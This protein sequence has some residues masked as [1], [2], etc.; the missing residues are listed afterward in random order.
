MKGSKPGILVLALAA[1]L[2]I[3]CRENKMSRRYFA[4]YVED[5][6]NGL[7]KVTEANGWAYHIQ[8]KPASYILANEANASGNTVEE[9][10][11]L[12]NRLRGAVWFNVSIQRIKEQISPLRYNATDESEYSARL[13]YFLNSAANDFYLIYRTDTLRP[14]S[15]L[16]ETTY[17]LAPKETMIVGFSLPG[18]QA[19]PSADMQLV[20]TD[21]IFKNGIIKAYFYQKDLHNIPEIKL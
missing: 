12:K 13:D 11:S 4:R 3:S 2:V 19:E 15:Y 17:N 10:T 16:F 14:I 21:N 20:Y 9:N 6:E 5:P 7:H 18:F 8:Y 1:M